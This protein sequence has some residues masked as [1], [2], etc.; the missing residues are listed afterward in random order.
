[1]KQPVDGN[2]YIDTT[3]TD[4]VLTYNGGKANLGNTNRVVNSV[5]LVGPLVRP[6]DQTLERLSKEFPWSRILRDLPGATF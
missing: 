6:D 1:M 4:S 2:F 3:F 5:L